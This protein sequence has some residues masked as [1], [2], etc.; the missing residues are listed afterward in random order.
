MY[1]AVQI[2][3]MTFFDTLNMFARVYHIYGIDMYL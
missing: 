1:Y 3:F 2:I